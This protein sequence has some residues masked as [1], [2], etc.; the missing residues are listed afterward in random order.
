MSK[1]DAE[2]VGEVFYNRFPEF[3]T[4]MEGV[5]TR[6]ENLV[7]LFQDFIEKTGLP[8]SEFALLIDPI[9]PNTGNKVHI[10]WHRVFGEDYT[11]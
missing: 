9:N 4:E 11:T 10:W 3:T 5:T 7:K 1:K 8:F 2:L 6:L